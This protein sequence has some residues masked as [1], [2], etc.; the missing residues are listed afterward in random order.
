MNNIPF[1]S[2]NICNCWW[3][4]TNLDE[5]DCNN[6]L[7][8]EEMEYQENQMLKITPEKEKL[9]DNKRHS[10]LE[11]LYQY[12]LSIGETPEQAKKSAEWDYLMSL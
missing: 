7:Y 11:R 12:F 1:I 2:Q 5:E 10:E 8:R 9:M 3:C 6:K 4:Q